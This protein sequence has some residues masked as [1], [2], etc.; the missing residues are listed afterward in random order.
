MMSFDAIKWD[1]MDI[2]NPLIKYM[3][4]CL[5]TL[6]CPTLLLNIFKCFQLQR[7]PLDRAYSMLPT[8]VGM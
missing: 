7:K 3:T 4:F 8:P 5:Y 6:V 1:L 2:L